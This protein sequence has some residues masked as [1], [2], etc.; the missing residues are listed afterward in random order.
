V[1]DVTDGRDAVGRADLTLMDSA[2]RPLWMGMKLWGPAMTL[3][4]VP[5]NRRL[6][7]VERKDALK[8]HALWN[9]MGGILCI[10]AR[11][12]VDDKKA[13]RRLCDRLGIKP[14]DMVG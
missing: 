11:I 6:P 2:I 7:I 12:A 5:A 13:R 9:Q 4:V 10:A 3:R 1:T 14:D 8:P